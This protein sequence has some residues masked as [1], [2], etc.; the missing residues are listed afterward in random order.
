MTGG[1]SVHLTPSPSRSDRDT[2]ILTERQAGIA[3]GLIHLPRDLADEHGAGALIKTKDR[4]HE[5]ALDQHRKLF[6]ELV[7][8]TTAVPDRQGIVDRSSSI[9]LETQVCR[10]YGP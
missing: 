2:Q 9:Q 3:Q 5:F 1:F 7:D 4:S 6:F 10:I 8:Q